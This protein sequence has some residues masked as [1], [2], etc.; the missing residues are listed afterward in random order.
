MHKQIYHNS[1]TGNY[2][3]QDFTGNELICWYHAWNLEE[4]V[5]LIVTC[6]PDLWPVTINKVLETK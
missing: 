5:R 3:T 4:E 2:Q 1:G 6:L